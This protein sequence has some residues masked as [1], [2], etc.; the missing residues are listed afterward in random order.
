MEVRINLESESGQEY[1]M[2][3]EV[4]DSSLRVPGEVQKEIFQAISRES[5]EITRRSGSKS[6]GLAITRRLLELLDDKIMLENQDRAGSTVHFQV[7]LNKPEI[8]EEVNKSSQKK[9]PLSI[10]P[11]SKILMVEDNPLNVFVGKKFLQ[12]WEIELQVAEN[13]KIAL[14]MLEKNEYDLIL[15]DLQMPEMDG[16]ETTRKIRQ[17]SDGHKASTPILAISAAGEKH[18]KDKVF[19]AGMNDFVYKPFNADELQEKL[20]KYLLLRKA[21]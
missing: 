21:S 18:V 14:E 5:R 11:H 20:T 19:E 9:D 15:M 6:L 13:G 8:S 4:K 3:F 7:K 17:L 16:Y 10:L 1:L 12:K 2:E